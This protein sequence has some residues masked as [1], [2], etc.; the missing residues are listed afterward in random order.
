MICTHVRAGGQPA[1]AAAA[2]AWMSQG[3]E[4]G[5]VSGEMAKRARRPTMVAPDMG[6]D[7]PGGAEEVTVTTFTVSTR[8]TTA[9][10]AAAAVAPRAPAMAGMGG[11][12]LQTK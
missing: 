9:A 7:A 2:P 12:A 11:A 5:G 1:A 4:G 10:A 6:G 3:G 8:I